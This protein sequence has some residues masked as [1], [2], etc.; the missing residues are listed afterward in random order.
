MQGPPLTRPQVGFAAAPKSVAPEDPRRASRPTPQGVSMAGANR[1]LRDHGASRRVL[2]A[3]S[4]AP[5]KIV[6]G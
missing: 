3:K 2:T 6:L 1:P 5:F 4:A